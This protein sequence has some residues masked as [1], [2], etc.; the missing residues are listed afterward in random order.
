MPI[1]V[2]LSKSLVDKARTSAQVHQRSISEQI[3]YWSKIGKISEEN[4]DLTFSFVEEILA[5]ELGPIIGEYSFSE[6]F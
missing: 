1:N 5:V 2:K 3:E 4:P 6:D